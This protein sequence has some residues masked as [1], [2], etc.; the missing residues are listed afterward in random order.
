MYSLPFVSERGAF[1]GLKGVAVHIVMPMPNSDMVLKE[2]LMGFSWD[3]HGTFL[4]AF[5][6]TLM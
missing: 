2:F 1:F 5:H 6:G 4:G 3:V